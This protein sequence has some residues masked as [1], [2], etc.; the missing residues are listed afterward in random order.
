MCTSFEAVKSIITGSKSK[1]SLWNINT[2]KEY[3]EEGNGA[4]GKSK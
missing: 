1:A 2:E 3:H 4:V